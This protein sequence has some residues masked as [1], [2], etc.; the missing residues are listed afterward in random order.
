LRL[1]VDYLVIFIILNQIYRRIFLNKNLRADAFF[2]WL[3]GFRW[4][5]VAVF[6]T[7]F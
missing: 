4:T 1:D 5:L 7:R 6:T 2:F 3:A